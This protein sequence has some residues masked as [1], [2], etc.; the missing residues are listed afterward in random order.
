MY[1]FTVRLF[2]GVLFDSVNVEYVC[3]FVSDFNEIF[4]SKLL[5]NNIKVK[6]KFVMNKLY[7]AV[8]VRKLCL[9]LQWVVIISHMIHD[10]HV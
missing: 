2:A 4:P 8:F 7:C 3:I 1:S 9:H 6:E 5:W 10:D